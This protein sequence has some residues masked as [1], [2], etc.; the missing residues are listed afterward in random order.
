MKLKTLYIRFFRSFNYDYLRKGSPNPDPDS[1]D[2]I[3]NQFYPFIK[4]HLEPEITTVVGAN[5]SGKSQVLAAIE[6][7]LTGDNI[8]TKDFCRYS[9]FFCVDK[10]LSKPEFGGKFSDLGN[11]DIQRLAEALNL[12]IN[13]K[14]DSFVFFRKN[15]G[16]FL[17]LEIDGE[18]K[19]YTLDSTQIKKIG[20]PSIYKIDADTPLPDSIPID[21]LVDSKATKSARS[22]QKLLR[23]QEV[24]RDAYDDLDSGDDQK[25]QGI[26]A[27]LNAA[28]KEISDNDP[29]LAK[30]LSLAETLLVDVVG[31]DR[32]AFKELR[33]AAKKSEGHAAGLVEQMNNKISQRLNFPR[34]WSQDK[35]FS[36]ILALRDF[37]LVFT[38]KDRTGSSYSFSERS[39][40][41]KYFLSYFVQY[42][43]YKPKGKDEILLMDEPDK[44]LSTSGQQDLLK[45]FD[46]LAMP[47]DPKRQASQVVYVTHSPFL[48]DKN[49]SE[50]IR[51]LEKG[52]G[53]EGTRIVKNAGR[54]HYEPLRSAFG[55]FVAETTFISNCNLM[56]EGQGDQILLANLS[57]LIRSSRIPNL[58]FLD[59]NTLT[60]VPSGSAEHI[61]YMVYL[62]RGRDVEKP[63]LIVLLD[64][65]SAGK[66]AREAL[67]K[68]FRKRRLLDKNFILATS[69]ISSK[70][71]ISTAEVLEIEDLIHPSMAT[72]AIRIVA[73]EV[74]EGE[75]LSIIKGNLKE[76]AQEQGEKLFVAS[77]RAATEAN[78]NAG[79]KLDKVAFARAV[80]EAVRTNLSSDAAKITLENFSILFSEINKKQRAAI[81]ERSHNLLN[82]FLK[83]AIKGFLDD[84]PYRAS[85][86][87]VRNFLEHIEHQLIEPI[88]ENEA[89]L[90]S[91]RKIRHKYSI[92]SML[93]EPIVEFSELRDD[94]SS[95]KY[96]AIIK[97][98]DTEKQDLHDAGVMRV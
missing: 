23:T 92:E 86:I 54:N 15:D 16:N 21:F 6:R 48:I 58:E 7:L 59:L 83:R 25:L 56:M 12:D 17:Y 91:I 49:F 31:I 19:I 93:S 77:Q 9:K 63:A 78:P 30:R 65:D 57:S 35:E 73:S 3:S 20:L 42:L 45:I 36:L 90:D 4:L 50:R 55:S 18:E 72:E 66:S 71:K 89:I 62:A 8:E 69:D 32:S 39:E 14:F 5:E 38:I 85:K 13:S 41:M 28:M 94:I 22:R 60:L 97:V 26:A 11:E 40:G 53:D 76:V 88:P 33:H 64:G 82:S 70:V 61:P 95:M 87:E 1:W 34:W 75:E 37:D 29:L 52:E 98:Q 51:V 2:L 80:V 96:E 24:L 46:Q 27:K 43:A 44:F 81:Y 47:E 68:D 74:F 79:L 67:N 84:H 10:E